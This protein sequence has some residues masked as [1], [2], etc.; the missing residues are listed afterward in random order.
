M[1][2]PLSVLV[3]LDGSQAATVALPVAR[4]LAQTLDASL[5][6][7]HVCPERAEMPA[8]PAA[9]CGLHP[10]ECGAIVVEAL[11]GQP[12]RE[13]VRA[14]E[15]WDPSFIVLC[16]CT[17]P[18]TERGVFG[19][20]AA[21]VLACARRPV[22]VVPPTRGTDPWALRTMLIPH[23]GVPAAAHKLASALDL[24]QRAGAAVC[25]LHVAC[26]HSP[27]ERE[28]GAFATPRY[29]DQQHH[30][31]PAWAREFVERLA[32]GAPAGLR[33]LRLWLAHGE[34]A[35]TIRQFADQHQADLV[36]LCSH[37]NL[38]PGHA[39]VLHGVLRHARVP[40]LVLRL[41]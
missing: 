31:W 23:E 20:V 2:D 12:A 37:G 40:V 29:V 41:E 14:A 24:A 30:E 3:P 5:H 16:A 22:V 33:S 19:P 1:K 18:R 4:A 26:P 39:A 27:P 38:E 21:E 11:C 9:A 32:M 34:P 13:I 17:G 6:V 36:V 28:P 25:V 35:S 7:V 8:D 15:E 10:D